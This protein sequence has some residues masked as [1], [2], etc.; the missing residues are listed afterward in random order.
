MMLKWASVSVAVLGA[1]FLWVP[2]AAQQNEL[3]NGPPAAARRRA[4]D[5][6]NEPGAIAWQSMRGENLY[7]KGAAQFLKGQY[8]KAASS[9][10]RAC[11][12]SNSLACTDLGVMYRRG[13]GVKR[14]YRRAIGLY[15]RGCDGGNALGCS[16]LAIFYYSYDANPQMAGEFLR[17]GCQLGDTGACLWLSYMYKDGT[18]ISQDEGRA[19]ERY[20]QSC[21]LRSEPV[22]DNSA[23]SKKAFE[24]RSG[25]LGGP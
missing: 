22:C 14:D 16:N 5:F 18:G 9:Y 23:T 11:D 8:A 20:E 4:S 1:S 7:E 13:Q 3:A 19:A 2:L 25:D 6:P 21:S 17:R 15:R 10:E 24:T 12:A